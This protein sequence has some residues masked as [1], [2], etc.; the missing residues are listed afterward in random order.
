MSSVNIDEHGKH[1]EDLDQEQ[2]PA[3]RTPKMLNEAD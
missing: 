1:S 2:Q 3:T